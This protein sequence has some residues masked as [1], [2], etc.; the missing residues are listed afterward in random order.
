M[1]PYSGGGFSRF[2]TW[3]FAA[4]SIAISGYA[5]QISGGFRVFSHYLSRRRIVTLSGF[6]TATTILWLTNFVIFL[7]PAENDKLCQSSKLLITNVDYLN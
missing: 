6:G 1:R 4:G 2:W 3:E 7:E 5:G